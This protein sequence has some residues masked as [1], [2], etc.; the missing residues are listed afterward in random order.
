M[1]W[2][3]TLYFY[4]NAHVL[5]VCSK[6]TKHNST[7][8]LITHRQ[9]TK[10][11]NCVAKKVTAS[12]WFVRVQFMQQSSISSTSVLKPICH[13]QIINQLQIYIVDGGWSNKR[14]LANRIKN[15][16][17]KSHTHFFMCLRRCFLKEKCIELSNIMTWDCSIFG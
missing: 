11:Q 2:L 6:D 5:I 15:L 8:E 16:C 10:F 4:V 13:A 9:S 3:K 7:T 17:L 12:D 1:A 14:A